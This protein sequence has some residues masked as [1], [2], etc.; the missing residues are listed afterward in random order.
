MKRAA[1][2]LLLDRLH[3]GAVMACMG[4]TVL[5]TLSLGFRVYQYFTDIKPEI[6]RKQILAKNELLKE[7][8][9]DISLYESNITLKE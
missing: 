4:I 2:N 7:G 6:Q 8:A 5:G 1:K 9:S 3:K